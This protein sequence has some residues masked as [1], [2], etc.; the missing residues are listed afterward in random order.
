MRASICAGLRDAGVLGCGKH[1]PGLG[2]ANLDSHHDLPSIDKA[3]KRLW[4]E[5]LV[6]YREMRKELPFVMVAHVCY[7]AVTGDRTPASLSSKWMTDILRKKIGYRGLIISDDLDMGAVL[8]SA[9]IE[10]AAVE[11]LR[12]GA[13]MFLVCQKEEHVWRAFEAVLQARRRRYASLRGSWPQKCARVLAFKKKSREI[14][15]RMAPMRRTEDGRS[16]APPDV[17]IQRRSALRTLTRQDARMIVAGVMSGTSADGINVALTRIQGRGFHSRV[18][19]LAHYEFPYPA[20]VRQAILG[21]MNATSANVADLARLNVVLG[22][23]YAEAVRGRAAA[24]K[25]RVRTCRMPR[26]DPLS[27]GNYETVPGTEDRLHMAD[28]RSRGDRGQGGSS[29]GLRLSARRH[30]GRRQGCAAG[31]VP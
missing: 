6:P 26:P 9:S 10:E 8:S 13:D 21:S 4:N 15:A 24:G 25:A 29:G 3:W 23:L 16:S 14:N 19:L 11:T 18:E 22:E 1:F 30:G 7:P 20:Q 17:G 5:D 28:G 31:S 27:S 2:E 12:A